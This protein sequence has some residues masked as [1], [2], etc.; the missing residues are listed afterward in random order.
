MLPLNLPKPRQET[1]WKKQIDPVLGNVLLQGNLLTGIQIFNGT[2]V[3]NTKLQRL[4]Q[5]WIIVDQDAQAEIYRSAAFNDLTLTLT[6]SKACTIA[7][8]VF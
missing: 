3:I 8:W 7:L 2:N 1:E 6:S 5:G 4:Q